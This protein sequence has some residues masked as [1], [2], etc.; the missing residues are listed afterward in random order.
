MSWEEGIATAWWEIT[1][2]WTYRKKTGIVR[3]LLQPLFSLWFHKWWEKSVYRASKTSRDT[4]HTVLMGQPTFMALNGYI[5]DLEFK[6]YLN[7]FTLRFI[8]LQKHYNRSLPTNDI[9]KSQLLIAYEGNQPP[10][11]FYPNN[12]FLIQDYI[13]FQFHFHLIKQEV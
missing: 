7:T 2:R 11:F 3:P 10:F 4:E 1:I 6:V 12:L 8:R 9:C 5:K 13:P